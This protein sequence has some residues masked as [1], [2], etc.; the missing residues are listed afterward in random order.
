LLTVNCM[1]SGNF[2]GTSLSNHDEN[3]AGY[4]PR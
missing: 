4:K 3:K 1:S 2:R